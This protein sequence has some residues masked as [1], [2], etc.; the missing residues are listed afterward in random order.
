MV[1]VHYGMTY[2]I[3]HP[4]PPNADSLYLELY[5]HAALGVYS[6]LID[7]LIDHVIHATTTY[8]LWILIRDYFPSNCAARYMMLNRHYDNLEQGTSR[9]PSCTS[10]TVPLLPIETIFSRVKLAK[11]N[12]AQYTSEVSAIVLAIHGNGAFPDGSFAASGSSITGAPPLDQT[13]AST[14]LRSATTTSAK[15]STTGTAPTPA[16]RTMV[17]ATARVA[18][19]GPRSW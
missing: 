14:A 15:A 19:G 12:L 5:A 9:S 1:L 11:E 16:I 13:I 18:V 8:D 10:D 2:L 6:T 3:E 17:I 7:S 4:P